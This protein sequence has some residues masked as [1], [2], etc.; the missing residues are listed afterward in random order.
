LSALNKNLTSIT[1]DDVVI[2]HVGAKG[3]YASDEMSSIEL[4]VFCTRDN[5]RMFSAMAQTTGFS[6]AIVAQMIADGTIKD[7]GVIDGELAVPSEQY[8]KRLK[9][10]RIN[11]QV[12]AK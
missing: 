2:A 5:E 10:S 4:S 12:S 1:D 6:A 11:V 7:L 8:I 9:E 3:V